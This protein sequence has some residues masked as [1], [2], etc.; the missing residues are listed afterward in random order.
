[1][2]HIMLDE[3]DICQKFL[4]VWS[5]IKNNIEQYATDNNLTMQQIFVLYHLCNQDQILMGTLAKTLHCDASNVTGMVDRLQSGG[6]ITRTEMPTDRRAR[7]LKITP[8]GRALIE[9]LV[10]RLADD[11]GFEQLSTTETT[12]LH[13]FFDKILA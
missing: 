11:V 3:L 2:N 1:M 7:Q 6:F 9:K 13:S 4:A 8:K 12:V 5:R 10:P